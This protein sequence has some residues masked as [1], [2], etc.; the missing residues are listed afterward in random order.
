[1]YV[2]KATN[3]QRR[4]A[5][6]AQARPGTSRGDATRKQQARRTQ[7]A[8]ETTGPNT[9]P[10]PGS[11]AEAE[12]SAS[13]RDAEGRATRKGGRAEE[14]EGCPVVPLPKRSPNAQ[15][16]DYTFHAAVRAKLTGQEKG[17]RVALL[18]RGTR[19]KQAEALPRAG[20]SSFG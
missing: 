14:R 15:P 6:A 1:M 3:G 20:N 17:L 5:K 12:R 16:L 11:I 4:A 7:A 10:A 9:P 18:R 13:L 8:S 19:S 2:R